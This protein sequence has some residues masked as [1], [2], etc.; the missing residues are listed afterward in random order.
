MNWMILMS[1]VEEVRLVQATIKAQ[2]LRQFNM[3]GKVWPVPSDTRGG[4]AVYPNLC[5]AHLS[6]FTDCIV[7]ARSWVE[8]GP[9]G[10]S[11]GSHKD[12]TST[13]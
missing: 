10:Y 7:A 6:H 11:E 8:Q 12:K 9:Q 2:R 4:G 3:R 1:C 5:F 13:T